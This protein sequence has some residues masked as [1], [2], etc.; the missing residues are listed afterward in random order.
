MMSLQNISQ[1][2]FSLRK[3]FQFTTYKDIR[4]KTT[5]VPLPP[6]FLKTK[7][8]DRSFLN[9]NGS[10]SYSST[11]ELPASAEVVIIGGGVV[12]TSTAFH[13]AKRGVNVA[14]IERHK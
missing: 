10:R 2:S 1:I 5:S 7:S 8:H 4:L 6:L 13:L 3:H 14:L 11:K 12:G 9:G